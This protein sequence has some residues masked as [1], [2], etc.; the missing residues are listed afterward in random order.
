MVLRHVEAL[1][2]FL[3]AVQTTCSALWINVRRFK[4]ALWLPPAAGGLVG[5]LNIYSHSPGCGADLVAAVA[6]GT[7][8]H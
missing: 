2:R 4:P 8:E 5:G 7:A 6:H 3:P 1:F